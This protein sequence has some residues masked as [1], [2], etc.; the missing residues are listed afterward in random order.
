MFLDCGSSTHYSPAYL[1]F[2]IKHFALILKRLATMLY[3]AVKNGAALKSQGEKSC[4]IKG[5]GQEMAAMMLML[6]AKFVSINTLTSLQPF[7]GC[8]L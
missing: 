4:E 2:L 5:D 3:T 7:L 1:L 6:T 8:H